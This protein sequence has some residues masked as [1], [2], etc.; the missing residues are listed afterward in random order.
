MLLYPVSAG[1]KVLSLRTILPG[2]SGT[3]FESSEVMFLVIP[4]PSGGA[5]STDKFVSDDREGLTT[6]QVDWMTTCCVAL[7]VCTCASEGFTA[8]SAHGD[9][10]P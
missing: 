1:S 7:F 2:S 6:C 8:Y 9:R 5:N 3:T 4:D 10:V